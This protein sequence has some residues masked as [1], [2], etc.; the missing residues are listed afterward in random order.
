MEVD[1]GVMNLEVKEC[2]ELPT[3]VWMK[4]WD[5]FSLGA[6]RWKQSC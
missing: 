5:D 2:Q 4:A 1:I 3:E 6:S